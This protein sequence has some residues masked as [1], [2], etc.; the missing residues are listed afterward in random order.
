MSS[1]VSRESAVSIVRRL[2]GAGHEAL[3]AGGCVRDMLLGLEPKDYDVATSAKP[4]EVTVL[5]D[6]VIPLGVAF[7]VVLVVIDGVGYEV[8]TFRQD[9]AYLDGRRPEGVVFTDAGGD[10][11]R[12]D[13]T[14]NGLFLDPETGT[15]VDYVGGRE[16]LEKEVIR[17][18]G[19]PVERF[20]EDRLRLLRAVR[21]ATRLDYEIEENTRAAIRESAPHITDVSWE[22]IRDEVVGM[23]TGPRAGRALEMLGELALL[24]EIL[25][26]V[27]AMKGVA[28]PEVFHPEG[29]VFEHTKIMLNLM[30]D[31]SLRL[32]MGVLLHDVGKPG[33]YEEADRIRFNEHDSAGAEIAGVICR[34]L[35][36]STADTEAIVS[37][38]HHHMRFI[39]VRKMKQSTL[40]RFIRMESFGDHLELHRLDC[41]GSHGGLENYEYAVEKTAE[42]GEEEVHP[43]RLVTGDDLIALGYEQGPLFGRILSAVEEEQLEGRLTQRDEA[44]RWVESRFAK[45]RS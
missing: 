23:F 5:F 36:F 39:N 17:A 34:R 25:P 11:L 35:R 1:T 19:D 9:Q 27:S 31:P 16:D 42:F 37:L 29:D 24:R 14:I 33:T 12:R 45:K 43:P 41:L 44:L 7:G 10:A 4:E 21:F 32:A 15:V 13:F 20:A 6:R 30:R 26:E 22:R 3:L 18:I 28:Q 38:V 2:R 40:K 8:A